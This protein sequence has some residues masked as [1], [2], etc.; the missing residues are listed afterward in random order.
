MIGVAGIGAAIASF[1]FYRWRQR[2]RAARIKI[3]VGAFLVARYGQV[4]DDFNFNCS[5]DPYWPV[6]VDFVPRGSALRHR[7]QFACA[8]SPSSYLLIS[9]TEEER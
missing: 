3:W 8:G 6:I 9:E 2:N 1:A 7:L 5:D 4:P